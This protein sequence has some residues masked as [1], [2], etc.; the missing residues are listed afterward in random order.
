MPSAAI[1]G[2]CQVISRPVAA[3]ATIPNGLTK[4]QRAFMGEADPGQQLQ[5]FTRDGRQIGR[6]SPSTLPPCRTSILTEANGF[7]SQ[8]QLQQMP[9]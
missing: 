3:V 1:T 8:R 5:I 2:H 9:T 6:Q 4:H 7:A